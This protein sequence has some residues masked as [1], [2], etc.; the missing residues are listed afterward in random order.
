MGLDFTVQIVFSRLWSFRLKSLRCRVV[1]QIG[2]L[3]HSRSSSGVYENPNLESTESQFCLLISARTSQS[4]RSPSMLR[5]MNGIRSA[6]PLPPSP[7]TRN[8]SSGRS[9][10]RASQPVSQPASN[11]RGM[12]F[13]NLFLMLQL[14]NLA[15]FFNVATLRTQLHHLP[16]AAG[17]CLVDALI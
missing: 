17:W 15:P 12:S 5:G 3:T 10:D 13:C 9:T 7:R 14:F 2:C 6:H 4:K 8:V 11:R 16:A 1:F